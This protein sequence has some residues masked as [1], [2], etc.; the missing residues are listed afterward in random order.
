MN[1][2]Y[3]GQIIT[4]KISNKTAKIIALL[5]SVVGVRNIYTDKLEVWEADECLPLEV[6]I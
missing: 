2:L 6:E 1:S 4:N 3:E 5:G